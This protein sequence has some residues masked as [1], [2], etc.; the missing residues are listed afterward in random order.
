LPMRF[1][2][3]INVVAVC[4]VLSTLAAAGVWSPAP[5][6]PA[7][8]HGEHVLREGRRVVIVEYERELP[9][10]PGQGSAKETHV[11]PPHALDGVEAKETVSE[12]A[13]GA[14]SNAAD[15]VA[16]AAEDGKEKLSNAKESA[17]GKVFGAVKR[18]KDR[19][20]GAAKG[21]EEGARDGVSRQLGVVQSKLYPVYFRAMA[22][23]VGLALAAHLLGRERSSFAA[24]AQSFNLL[25]ALGLVLANMLLL[26]PKATKV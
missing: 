10:T 17:T 16:G 14:V 25:S 2:I 22:Y 4:L 1:P 7:Q 9:L 13:R 15:K 5:P 6:P 23:C 18:C 3:M 12:E 24:R 19:L 21:L 20:C 26:E 11:L 8:Q